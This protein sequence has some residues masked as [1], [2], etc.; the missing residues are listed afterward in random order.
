MTKARIEIDDLIT[1]LKGLDVPY[2]FIVDDWGY[3]AISLTLVIAGEGAAIEMM[4][5]ADGVV[6]TKEIVL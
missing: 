1:K 3:G 5:S 2:H 6:I 4:V